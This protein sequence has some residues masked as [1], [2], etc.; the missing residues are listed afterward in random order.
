MTRRRL[1]TKTTDRMPS[2]I[3]APAPPISSG[4][5]TLTPVEASPPPA[6]TDSLC[7]KRVL[8]VGAGDLGCHLTVAQRREIGQTVKVIRKQFADGAL[9]VVEVVVPPA[10]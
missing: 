10:K 7:G 9:D 1:V 8:V 6:V 3:N 2:R 5:L 4:A